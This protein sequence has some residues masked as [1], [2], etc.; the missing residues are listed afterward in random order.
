VAGAQLKDATVNGAIIQ[1]KD[2]IDQMIK[3]GAI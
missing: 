3:E 1:L 2:T